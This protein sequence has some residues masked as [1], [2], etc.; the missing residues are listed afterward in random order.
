[1][2]NQTDSFQRIEALKAE[3]ATLEQA[4]IQELIDELSCLP[5]IGPRSA[6]RI[7]FYLLDAP[8]EDVYALADTLRRV[9]QQARFCE[10]CFN[11]SQE[12]RCRICRDCQ[13]CCRFQ[14]RIP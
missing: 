3:I 2:P 5:G 1:M 11:V 8:E 10:V 14:R 13:D 6:Q 4:A 9:K 7:A 12:E